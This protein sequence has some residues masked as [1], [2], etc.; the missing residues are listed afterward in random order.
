MADQPVL[1]DVI[2]DITADIRT[3]VRGE[4]E[5]VRSEVFPGAKKAGLGAG[6]L[7]AAGVVGLFALNVLLLC[8]GFLFANLFWDKTATPVG[9]F[10]FGFL[11]AFG[12][13]LILAVILAVIGISLVKKLKSPEAA[14]A[15]G[16]KTL[17]S[18]QG[19][20]TAGFANVRHLATFGK[21]SI[22]RDDKGQI[23][24]VVAAHRHAVD[25]TSS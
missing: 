21:K 16:T 9:A 20:M 17:D 8:L 22:T 25:G 3:I 5:L 24:T 13:Y 14:A 7:V 23:V 18:L 12:V 2:G 11:C 4:L 19:A 1:G 15:Q 6:V 10:G